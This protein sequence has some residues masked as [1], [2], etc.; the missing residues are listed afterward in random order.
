MRF[1]TTTS[2]TL[3]PGALWVLVSVLLFQAIS[4]TPPGLLLVLDPTGGLLRMPRENLVGTPF[5]DFRIPGL[6]LFIVL[7]LGAFFMAGSL[8]LGPEWRWTRRLDAVTGHH[9]AWAGTIVFGLALMIWISVQV[10]MI[11]LGHWLQPLY[12]G[13]G[14]TIFLLSL[15]PAVR[16]HLA[17]AITRT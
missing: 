4:A 1:N 17:V 7:G 11:G 5:H 14:L 12:F 8:V 3:R 10:A 15:L 2:S 9:W 13:V 16:R 6:I